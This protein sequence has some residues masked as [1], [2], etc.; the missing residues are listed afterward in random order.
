MKRENIYLVL[1]FIFVGSILFMT[2]D[3][4][5]IVKETEIKIPGIE[6]KNTMDDVFGENSIKEFK[7]GF[8]SE[9]NIDGESYSF[10]ECS[11]EELIENYS[12]TEVMKMYEEIENDEIP[13]EMLEILEE[14]IKYMYK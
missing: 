1:A 9:C 5:E 2:L 6:K 12:F 3:K 13:E 8:M 11:Y 4:S 7:E 10:C 14:C